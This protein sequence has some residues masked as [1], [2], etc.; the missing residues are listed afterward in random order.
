MAIRT[1]SYL[2]FYFKYIFLII[3]SKPS[4]SFSNSPYL[5]PLSLFFF[6][7]PS[8]PHFSLLPPPVRTNWSQKPQHSKHSTQPRPLSLA[9]FLS[10]SPSVSLAH[11]NTQESTCLSPRLSLLLTATHRNLHLSLSL[12]LWLMGWMRQSSLRAKLNRPAE[13]TI[14]TISNKHW[15]KIICRYAW[16]HFREKGSLSKTLL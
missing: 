1:H 10:F 12:S 6:S 3:Q 14:E 4:L 8:V 7:S 16:L 11:T 13:N 2:Y 15:P 9:L 5:P